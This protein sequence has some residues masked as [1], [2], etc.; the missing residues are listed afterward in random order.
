MNDS[1]DKKALGLRIKSIRLEKG[2][3]LEEFGK[4]FG[5][6]KGLVSRWENGLSVPNADRLKSIAKI[7]RISVNNL[8]YGDQA[9]SLYNWEKVR[10][11]MNTFF[12]NNPI[13]EISFLRTKNIID[14]AFFLNLGID[15]IINLYMY[16]HSGSKEVKTLE[17]LQ[18]YFEL[19]SEGLSDYS[20]NASLE[21]KM[22]RDIMASFAQK[23]ANDIKRYIK[24]GIW[25]SDSL[26]NMKNNNQKDK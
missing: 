8:L 7:G 18:E 26:Y 23:N 3:T 1:I 6:G 15:D 11:L 19:T 10:S 12:N 4:L 21:E 14:K 20:E 22:D 24:S 2:M 17:D 16:H 25:S 5:A 9:K 13:D